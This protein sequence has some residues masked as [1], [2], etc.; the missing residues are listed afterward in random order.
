MEKEEFSVKW[1]KL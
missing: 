1:S